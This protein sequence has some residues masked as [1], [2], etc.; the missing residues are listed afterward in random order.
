MIEKGLVRETENL[1]NKGYSSG[2]KPMKSIG[3]RH[4]IGFLAGTWDLD[5]ATCQLQTDTRRYAKRQL[6]WFRGDPK[7]HWFEPE[8]RDGIIRKIAEFI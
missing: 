7:M 2:L 3:Y 4:M 8:D 1:L 5:E 6:T